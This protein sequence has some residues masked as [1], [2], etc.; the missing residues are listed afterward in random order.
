M[1]INFELN[2]TAR[3]GKELLEHD[4]ILAGD[5]I[6]LLCQ[7]NLLIANLQRRI[8]EE[9]LME[10]KVGLQDDNIPF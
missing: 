6:Q 9:A 10:F 2:L 3:N 7:F 4:K 5:L 8:N 1:D